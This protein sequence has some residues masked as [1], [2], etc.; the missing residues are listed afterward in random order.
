MTNGENYVII[1]FELYFILYSAYARDP[2]RNNLVKMEQKK[3]TTLKDYPIVPL[4]GKIA[5]P[6]MAFSIELTRKC[7]IKAFEDAYQKGTKILLVPQLDPYEENPMQNDFHK[8][9]TVAKISQY[10]KRADNRMRVLFTG[11]QTAKIISVAPSDDASFWQAQC[12]PRTRRQ[13]SKIDRIAYLNEAREM[14]MEYLENLKN[15]HKISLGFIEEIAQ[16]DDITALAN[17]IAANLLESYDEKLAVY[18]EEK[19]KEKIMKVLDALYVYT[20]SLALRQKIHDKVKQRSD[21]SQKEYYLNEQLRAIQEELGEDGDNETEIYKKQIAESKMPEEAKERLTKEATKLAKMPMNSAEYNVICNYIEAC[22]EL[23]WGKLDEDRI[24]IPLAEKILERDHYGLEKVKE[25]VL[26]YLAV[27][28]LTPKVKNQIIC[29]VGPPGTG[30]TSIAR[31][32]AE[33]MNRKYVRVS[34]GGVRDEADIRGHRKTYIGSMPGRIIDG[35]RR[36]GSVNPLMLLDE[37]DKLTRDNHGDPASALM[38]V[39]DSEQNKEF[40]DH[41]IEFPFDL[42]EVMFIATA[43]TLDTIPRPLLD[44]MEVIHLKSYST[45]EKLAIAKRYLIPKQ[46]ERHG[47]TSDKLKISQAALKAVISSYTQEAG[48]RNLER[49]IGAICRKSAK[50]IVEGEEC[51]KVTPKNLSD[52]LGA[53]KITPETVSDTDEVGVVNGLAYTELGGTL[54]KVEVAAVPGTGKIELTG[55]LG[56]VMK[57]SAKAALTYIRSHC[58]EWSIDGDFYTKKD[59]HIHFP[60]GAVPK[61]GPSAGVTMVS[62]IVSELSGRAVKRSVAMTGEVTLKGK[63][64]AIGGLKEKTMAAYNAGVTTVL[65]PKDNLKDLDEID[66]T[67][68]A[69]LNFI[70]CTTVADV[71]KNAIV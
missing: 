51:V 45:E 8:V 29:L 33:A 47:V 49:E 55:S 59:I 3:L 64:L 26:E 18:L 40:R 14:T 6:D 32:V 48:V 60:E 67:V 68:R 61:D 66:K 38:E 19:P 71:L 27:R 2:E 17:L 5:F 20:E 42:S 39:L 24:D 10:M 58:D 28:K 63:V 69:S 37:I 13:H 1:Q 70:P 11:L 62:A 43:N 22:L 9:G 57:E 12:L 36:A 65:L 56:D 16:V 35:I 31:S 25:R 34:L 4:D 53:E 23:P 46:S 41:F 30:K 15:I 52:F 44:R 21:R 50:L 54:L 7:E